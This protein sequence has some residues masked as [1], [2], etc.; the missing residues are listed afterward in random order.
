[1]TLMNSGYRLLGMM[2]LW[3][4][5]SFVAPEARAADEHSHDAAHGTLQLNDGRKWT[6]DEPLRQAMT[7]LSAAMGARLPAIHEDT[8]PTADYAALGRAVDGEVGYMIENCKLP[9][10]A[11]AMLH[12]VL[13]DIMQGSEA[14]QGKAQGVKHRAGAVKI[15]KALYSYGRYFDHPG[16]Q[17]PAH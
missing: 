16:W 12:L 13:V 7:R 9:S 6:T 11:D 2:L 15:V 3:A 5:V 10:D 1:M 17:P 4:S 8:L 14:M